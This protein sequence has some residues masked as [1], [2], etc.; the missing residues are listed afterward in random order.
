MYLVWYESEDPK[1]WER[2]PIKTAVKLQEHTLPAT[3]AAAHS[4]L[5]VDEIEQHTYR[6]V[7][8]FLKYPILAIAI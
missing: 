3:K 2:V 6:T 8:I 7:S 4:I 1:E 5:T